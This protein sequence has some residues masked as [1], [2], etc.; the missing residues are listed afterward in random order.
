M[1]KLFERI[2]LGFAVFWFF[3]AAV[4]LLARIDLVWWNGGILMIALGFGALAD[5][6]T[7][8][9]RR[10]ISELDFLSRYR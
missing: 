10:K 2:D 8:K 1:S 9:T 6:Q 3:M 5:W 4:V 7:S